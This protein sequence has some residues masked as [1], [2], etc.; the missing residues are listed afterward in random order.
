MK[1]VIQRVRRASVEVEGRRT[2]QIGLG[3][4]LLV[5]VEKEDSGKEAA[6]LAGK[7]PLLRIFGDEE[8]KMN[9]S[10]LDVGG[11]ILAVSQFTLAA[12]LS[13]GRR[14]GFE[15]AAA[16]EEAERLFALFVSELRANVADVQTGLFRAHM[17]VELVNDGPVTFLLGEGGGGRWS[18]GSARS[19]LQP[20][21]PGSASC[22][23]KEKTRRRISRTTRRPSGS[24]PE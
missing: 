4:L 7:I 10:L 5:C 13:R 19:V 1:I 22:H 20:R 16:P 8:G 15:R 11:S 21:P 9:R 12:D 18:A 14:P 2:A 6:A 3:L 17:D 23:L 24:G